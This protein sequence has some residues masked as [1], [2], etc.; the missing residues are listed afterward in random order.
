[1]KK[2]CIINGNPKRD[3]YCGALAEA[4]QQGALSKDHEVRVFSVGELDFDPILREGY[5]EKQPLEPDLVAVQEAMKWAHH[6]VWIFPVWWGAMPAA[7]K[8][9]IDRIFLPGF[10]FRFECG[11]VPKRLLRGRSARVITTMDA[12]PVVYN[13]LYGAPVHTMIRKTVLEFCGVN[14][15]KITSLGPLG[16]SAG[17]R[18]KSWL[19]MV[20]GIG[21]RAD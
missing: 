10:A 1:M 12:P 16:M 21:R 5:D 6:S 8:G 15:V 11:P 2:I 18:K 3:S 17:L 13:V 19:S 14:P 4:Y 7:L 9:L 20:E